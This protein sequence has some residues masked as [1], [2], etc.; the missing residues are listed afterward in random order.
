MAPASRQV[1]AEN[2]RLVGFDDLQ[3]RSAYQPLIVKQ[4]DRWLAYVGH[5][6]GKSLNPINGKVEYNGTSI[7][8]VSDPTQPVY[9]H[10]IEGQTGEGEAGGAQMVRICEGKTLP[11]GDPAKTYLLR[12][13]GSD[14]HEIWDVT[15]P[16]NPSHL[17]TIIKGLKDTHKNFWECDTGIA[18]LISDGRPEGF[19]S[20]RITKIYDLSDPAHPKFI[21]NFA[22][23]GQEPGSTMA[24][25]PEGFANTGMHILELTGEA[26]AIANFPK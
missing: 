14:G 11:K 25:I 7:V 22:L 5:H 19:R 26:R 10:H 17:T 8:D 20:S 18:Y 12:T 3:A 2:M 6:G 15:D 24:Q 23:V 1:D 9:L 21:R 13:Y 4:G 16:E